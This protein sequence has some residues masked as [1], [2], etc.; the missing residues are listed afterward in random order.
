MDAVVAWLDHTRAGDLASIAGLV[1]A[2]VGFA[3]T[4]WN[5]L[6]SKK[7]AQ[8]AEQ[9]ALDARRAIGFFDAVT[10][11]SAAISVLEEIRRLHRNV[12]GLFY[13]IGTLL[14]GKR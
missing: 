10:E 6:A 9:A 7:A 14:S 8:R 12:P 5:V 4:I 1:I 2:L 11:L 13:R 3:I